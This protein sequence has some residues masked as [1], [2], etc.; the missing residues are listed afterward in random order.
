MNYLREVNIVRSAM[1]AES[2]VKARALGDLKPTLFESCDNSED[3]HM[4][5]C[6]VKSEIEETTKSTKKKICKIET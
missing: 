3:V 4:T 5:N 6:S 1:K 2:L